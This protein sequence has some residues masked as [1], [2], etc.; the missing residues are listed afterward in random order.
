MAFTDQQF[1]KISSIQS[2]LSSLYF[3]QKI[4]WSKINFLMNIS[5][6][7]SALSLSNSGILLASCS[8]IY[9]GN[10]DSISK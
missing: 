2:K 6:I 5:D 3:S 10:N 7:S 9:F 1:Y 8:V 4:V